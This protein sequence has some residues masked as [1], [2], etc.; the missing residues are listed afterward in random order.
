[1]KKTIIEKMIS[2]SKSDN[3]HPTQVKS[4]KIIY[5]LCTNLQ[6]ISADIKSV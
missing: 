6:N 4:E 2:T 3:V 5:K 1:M